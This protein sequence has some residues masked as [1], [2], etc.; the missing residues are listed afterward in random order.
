M[1]KV[2][3]IIY[4]INPNIKYDLTLSYVRTH[5]KNIILTIKSKH[6][7]T[8]ITEAKNIKILKKVQELNL[9]VGSFSF[10][11]IPVHLN[12]N[13]KQN[14]D[15]QPAIESKSKKVKEIESLLY[16]N[17]WLDVETFVL[18]TNNTSTEKGKEILSNFRDVW[19]E[20]ILPNLEYNEVA[21]L[22]RSSLFRPFIKSFGGEIWRIL[23]EKD[24]PDIYLQMNEEIPES[25]Q[26]LLEKHSRPLE[27]RIREQTIPYWKLLYEYHH[28][29]KYRHVKQIFMPYFVNYTHT[30]INDQIYI[31]S[32]SFGIIQCINI[33]TLAKRTYTFDTIVLQNVKEMVCNDTYMVQYSDT[34]LICYNYITNE[35]IILPDSKLLISYRNCSF[36]KNFVIFH[37]TLHKNGIMM[38]D[39]NT[40]KLTVLRL[41][42]S[43][44]GQTFF[45]TEEQDLN[46][47]SMTIYKKFLWQNNA[48]TLTSVYRCDFIANY[49]V[50]EDDFLWISMYNDVVFNNIILQS[51]D[52]TIGNDTQMVGK[53]LYSYS[54]E[55]FNPSKIEIIRFEV[56]NEGVLTIFENQ[57]KTLE[58]PNQFTNKKVEFMVVASGILIHVSGNIYLLTFDDTLMLLSNCIVCNV[59]TKLGCEICKKPICSE[60]HHICRCI[61]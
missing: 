42:M 5:K 2:N 23:F 35:N 50:N 11:S 49:I 7:M 13:I 4:E 20:Q 55:E 34:K 8:E 38:I 27:Q 29:A 15:V 17:V 59:S 37:D 31:C 41:K 51:N 57:T 52:I 25:L 12:R 54:Y 47:L 36:I 9:D 24:F 40:L 30:C 53:Y 39:L 22:E 26:T 56:N 6:N 58:L 14:I 46:H 32:P 3:T 10:K 43:H 48:F 28:Q 60:K 45:L 21:G 1:Q 18:Y 19:F 61:K 16:E 44:V 33:N